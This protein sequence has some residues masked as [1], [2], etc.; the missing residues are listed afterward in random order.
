MLTRTFQITAW[1][2]L[3]AAAP[4]G[5]G[6][7]MMGDHRRARIIV[8]QELCLL[9]A[10]WLNRLKKLEWAGRV[11]A[12][13]VLAT[14]T[15]MVAG[16]PDGFHDVAL[17][18]FPGAVILAA[19]LADFRFYCAFAGLTLVIVIAL[20]AE[21]AD[22]VALWFAPAIL[23]AIATG[24][25]LMTRGAWDCAAAGHAASKRLQFQ[26]DR[27]PL[28]YIAWDR[29]FRITEWNH[30]AE[31]I[32]GWSAEEANGRHGYLLV[33]LDIRSRMDPV[34]GKLL[35]GDETSYSLNENITKDGK[36]LLCEWFNTS[37]R[38]DSGHVTEVLSIVHDI[39]AQRNL[40]AARTQSE[41]QFRQV[42]ENSRD[43]MRLSDPEGRVLRVN[44]AYCQLVNKS[45][46]ELEGSLLTAI[47]AAHAQTSRLETYRRRVRQREIA[48]RMERPIELWDGRTIWMDVSN[49]IIESSQGARVLSIFR[50]VTARK[51]D[52][53]RLNEAVLTAEAAN[54][55]KSEFLANMS[56]EIRTPMNGV[57][58]M[59]GL[60]LD[61]D[62][63]EDQRRYG[64]IVRSSGESL[65]GIINNVLDFSKI[66][67][68]KLELETLD[69][70]LQI[71]LDDFVATLAVLASGKGLEL[72]CS[73]DHAVPIQLRGDPGRLLQIL[74]NLVG[75]AVKFTDKGDVVVS[76]SL[77]EE[78]GT[79]CLLRFS[80]RDTGIGIPGDKIGKLF[81]GFS[82]VD[83]STTRKYGGTGLGLAI[84]KQLA[85]LMGGNIGAES[86]DGAGSEFWF[87][88][89]MVKQPLGVQT[90][91]RPP[92]GLLGVRTLIV[93]DNAT[94]RRVLSALM[95]KWGMRPEEAGDGPS[96]IQALHMALEENDP[97]RVA[98]IDK[99]MPG[100]DG[101]ALGQ[102]INSDQRVADARLVLLTT[103][104]AGVDTGHFEAI[105][106][107]G[108]ARKPIQQRELLAALS[109]VLTDAPRPVAKSILPHDLDNQ[110][111]QIITGVKA[112]ILV[113][114]DNIINQKVA[115]GILKKLGLR[116]DA[117]ADGAEAVRALES[118]P[119]DLVLMDIQMPVMDGIEATRQIR[120]A[121]SAVL[122]HDVPIIAMTAYAMPGDRQR[123][124]DS[125]MNDYVPKPVS[126][127]SLTAALTRWLAK[128]GSGRGRANTTETVVPHVD[129]SI[130]A[131]IELVS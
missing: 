131:L 95:T 67:A 89:R 125:G 91:G 59:T 113:V 19:L 32:F 76:V 37:V 45:R 102:I 120:D 69:F 20:A 26:M 72:I 107:K 55:S 48:S 43:G 14:A 124:L 109:R 6:I 111:S 33:P 15:L 36:R 10:L 41:E 42:W 119:Y 73:I 56:H 88:V 52:E 40:E 104:G 27:M 97:F 129:I 57:I 74:N 84:S 64:E 130:P 100:T 110:W 96:A 116:A 60:L 66:E 90:T 99:H 50:D 47:H 71:L 61:T 126:V 112:L 85:A 78:S 30:A 77:Q 8:L 127:Q 83:A 7:A 35:E 4:P 101:E 114:D 31:R 12:I 103:L 17:L 117:V 38:D 82:Q 128:K 23:V 44:S 9:A 68:G 54:R 16:S 62:L 93:D 87:T 118:I 63:S 11:A 94:S 53:A 75:N 81:A 49:S 18:V 22:A 51:L 39:T 115:M 86:E 25:G 70:D 98:L 79:E 80:V 24:V 108:H 58:G 46:Q 13:G 92:A 106:F 5:I 2:T 21:R 121:H 34:W 28:A 123:F 29:E 65:L 1:V 3:L 105:G 122:D